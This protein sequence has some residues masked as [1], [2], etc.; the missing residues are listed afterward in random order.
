M[1]VLFID[2][3]VVKL[4]ENAK[5]NWELVQQAKHVNPNYHWLHLNSFPSG[6]AILETSEPSPTLLQTAGQFC[7]SNTKY[8]NLKDV[9]IIATPISNLILT[10]TVGEVAFKTNRKTKKFKIA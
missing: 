2:N 3:V 10:D 9:Y 1:K 8:K 5:E 4:G 7:K 6:H